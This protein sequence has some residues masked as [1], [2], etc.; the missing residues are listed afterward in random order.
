MKPIILDTFCKAGG[1]STGYY[2]AGFDVVG[3]DIE[4]QKNYPF[5]FYQGDAIE[6]IAK[7]GQEF[8]VIH[9]SPPCQAY[10][11]S[12]RIRKNTHP[13][14]IVPTRNA[15]K[16]T[17]KPY[18]IENVV[19][20]PLVNPIKLTG[21]MFGL[22]TIR[23]RLFE[24]NFDLPL[25]L[26]LSPSVK[27]T[28]M[29]RMVEGEYIQVVGHFSGVDYAKKAMGIDWMTRDELREAIPPAYTKWIGEQIIGKII[30]LLN[31]EQGEKNEI[32]AY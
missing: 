27:Q 29:G 15:L 2:L 24:C 22:M 8:D 32:P 25:I 12:Q 9:A 23:P 10:T 6:F 7:H 14:L 13:D 1:A 17:G 16:E 19:G 11:K 21:L 5:E 31:L 18:I 20:A 4:P 30:N 28:K 26:S 3:V